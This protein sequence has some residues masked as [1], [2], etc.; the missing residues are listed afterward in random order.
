MRSRWVAGL[1]WAAVALTAT[2]SLAQ[3]PAGNAD[4]KGCP[5]E[6][7][8]P[9]IAAPVLPQPC[10]RIVAVSVVPDTIHRTLKHNTGTLTVKIRS[11]DAYPGAPLRPWR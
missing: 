9:N 6:Q 1:T 4:K 3:E 10:I 7:L 2:A 11:S 8:S 5:G